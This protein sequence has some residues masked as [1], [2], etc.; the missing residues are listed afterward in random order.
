MYISGGNEKDK[1][2]HVNHCYFVYSIVGHMLF[3][4]FTNRKSY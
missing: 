4:L 1:I 3:S 2:T